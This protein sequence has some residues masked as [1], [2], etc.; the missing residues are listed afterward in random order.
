[1]RS[2]ARHGEKND[3]KRGR[4]FKGE[5]LVFEPYTK[6]VFEESFDWIASRNLFPEGGMGSGSYEK[7]VITL[8]A[9]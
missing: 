2:N 1:M 9:E 6:E 7:S 3:Q 8:A 5:R 4:A